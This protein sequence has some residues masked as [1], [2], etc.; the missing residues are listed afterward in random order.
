MWYMSIKSLE[1]C[2]DDGTLNPNGSYTKVTFYSSI[3][4]HV[5]FV[6]YRIGYSITPGY[7]EQNF[8]ELPNLSGENELTNA[9]GIIP[10]DS[11][12][13]YEVCVYAYDKHVEGRSVS[14]TIG[15]GK[16]LFEADKNVYAIGIGTRAV[17][18]NALTIGLPTNFNEETNLV[19]FGSVA[20]L[21]SNSGTD[22]YIPLWV[23]NTQR[24]ILAR[25][26]NGLGRIIKNCSV[27]DCFIVS[28]DAESYEEYY[29]CGIR[30][31]EVWIRTDSSA[32]LTFVCDVV[33]SKNL[34]VNVLVFNTFSKKYV[35]E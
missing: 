16:V 27:Y 30:C 10:T 5:E 1:R 11:K 26:H 12:Y 17:T 31:T 32:E 35:K 15:T 18:S 23:D 25:Y 21:L 7:N 33:P 13:A 9:T 34:M 4:S 3:D 14:K 6:K 8:V 19:R 29:N 20:L 24:S 22:E 28:P 2:N